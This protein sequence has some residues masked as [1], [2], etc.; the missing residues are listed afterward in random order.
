MRGQAAASRA[1][2]SALVYRI[3]I[4]GTVQQTYFFFKHLLPVVN[5][6]TLDHQ[7]YALDQLL[8][9][10]EPAVWLDQFVT[11][12]TTEWF[13]FFYF[14]YFFLLAAHVLPI[15]FG[16]REPDAA[17][18]VHAR[19]ADHRLRR[20]HRLHPGA[21]LRSVQGHARDVQARATERAVD[22]RG[23]VHGALERRA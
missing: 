2:G 20:S 23:V 19:H 9:G 15:L 21:R 17:R 18:R 8:F 14:C 12:L 7:L 5:P 22:G 16:A 11:P 4:Y 13:A 10:F 1:S 6:G 3:G